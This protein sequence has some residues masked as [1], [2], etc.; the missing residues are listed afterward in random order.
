MVKERFSSRR[1]QKLAEEK[2]QLEMDVLRLEK[3]K[4]EAELDLIKEDI[5]TK[6]VTRMIMR[7]TA[8]ITGLSLIWTILVH[9]GVFGDK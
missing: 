1:I 9:L 3:V 4:R 6:Q 5:R 2:L 7:A 8:T